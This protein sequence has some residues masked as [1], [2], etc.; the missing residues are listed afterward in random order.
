MDVLIRAVEFAQ[1]SEESNSFSDDDQEFFIEKIVSHRGP[2]HKR[3]F[4]VK[5]QGYSS[6]HDLWY[7]EE[8]LLEVDDDTTTRMLA[9]YVSSRHLKSSLSR[10]LRDPPVSFSSSDENSSLP[11][12]SRKIDALPSADAIEECPDITNDFHLAMRSAAVW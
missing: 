8:Q 7:T 1:R 5:F 10:R 3:E 9:D 12:K 11:R 2:A 6:R 4:R